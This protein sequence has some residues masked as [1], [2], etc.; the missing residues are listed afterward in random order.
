MVG[1]DLRVALRLDWDEW[2]NEPGL[3][4]EI[5]DRL[6]EVMPLFAAMREEE[7]VARAASANG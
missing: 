7:E 4:E 1:R 6:R 5:V 3:V 2:A